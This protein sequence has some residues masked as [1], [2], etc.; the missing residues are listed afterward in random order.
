MDLDEVQC[1]VANLIDK[2]CV[3]VCVCMVCVCGCVCAWCVCVGVCGCA[4]R[5]QGVHI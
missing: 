1:I 2:V 4:P 5:A 3:G